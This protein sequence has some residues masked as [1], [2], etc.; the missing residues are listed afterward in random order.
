MARLAVFWRGWQFSKKAGEGSGAYVRLPH[1][2]LFPTLQSYEQ[3][4]GLPILFETKEHGK[5]IVHHVSPALNPSILEQNRASL[6]PRIVPKLLVQGV[7]TG[8]E[9]GTV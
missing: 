2:Y 9:E 7:A 3:P 8:T 4:L 5:Y 1:I 6:V